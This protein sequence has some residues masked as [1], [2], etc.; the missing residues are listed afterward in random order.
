VKKQIVFIDYVPNII[1]L[2]ISWVLKS[3]GK[4][5]TTLVSFSK[6][7]MDFYKN[8]YDEIIILDIKHNLNPKNLIFIFKKILSKEGRR[9]I[10]KVI[11][12]NPYFFQITGPDIFNFLLM[13][14]T[15]KRPKIYFAYDVWGFYG[16]K[17]SLKNPG[18]K[19]NIQK[20]IERICIKISDGIIHKGP[21]KELDFLLYRVSKPHYN[22]SPGCLD[23][24]TLQPKK[25]K[26]NRDIHLVFAGG[27]L[28]SSDGRVHF[29]EIVKKITSQ[30]I[31]FHTFGGCVDPKDNKV[32]LA[33]AKKNKYF[34]FHGRERIDNLNKKIADYA[35]GINPDFYD[36]SVINPLW[37]KTSVANKISNYIEAGIAII[38][39]KDA[40]YMAQIVKNLGIGF[41]IE[42]K[43]LEDLKKI[44]LQQDYKK[45]KKNILKAQKEL[46]F[47]RKIVPEL[48]KFY[49]KIVNLK[50]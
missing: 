7:D 4:Y 11:K 3:S 34:H 15:K 20:I 33:E 39:N 1:N 23:E 27:P 10:H 24:W 48:E 31:N 9:F 25:I 12:L 2:K 8:A 13:L 5:R 44:I 30:N 43:K 42:Y 50:H 29:L 16:K 47:N 22:I 18:I 14:I 49:E 46:S 17:L 19:E 28:K 36:T 37:P 26:K 32:F 40:E 21:E 6:V 41:V 35:Y 38:I 45:M